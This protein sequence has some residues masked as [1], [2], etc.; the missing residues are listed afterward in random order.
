M[1]NL[2][3]TCVWLSSFVLSVAS[4]Y[5]WLS[6]GKSGIRNFMLVFVPITSVVSLFQFMLYFNLVASKL[7]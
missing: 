5:V 6:C 2:I 3:L 7:D 4:L 1:Y